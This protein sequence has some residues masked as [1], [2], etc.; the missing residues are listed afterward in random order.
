MWNPK[1]QINLIREGEKVQL[2][3]DKNK[4]AKVSK[5]IEHVIQLCTNPNPITAQMAS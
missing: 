4:K 5:Y 3:A 1:R 2:I